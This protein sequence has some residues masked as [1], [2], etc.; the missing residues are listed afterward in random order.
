MFLLTACRC[1]KTANTP[2]SNQARR[3][4][5]LGKSNRRTWIQSSE[6]L[7]DYQNV[8]RSNHICRHIFLWAGAVRAN[9]ATSR[10][11]GR[12]R[13]DRTDGP[14]ARWSQTAHDHLRPQVSQRAVAN[15]F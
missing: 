8:P 12:L 2:A 7:N 14:D 4:G 11:T 3:C 15:S 5:D 1:S 13:K 10:S 9:A 6:K